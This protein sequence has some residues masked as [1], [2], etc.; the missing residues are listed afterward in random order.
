MLH[1]MVRKPSE[2]DVYTNTE[3]GVLHGGGQRHLH[4]VLA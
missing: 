1:S 3:F 2:H 4:G